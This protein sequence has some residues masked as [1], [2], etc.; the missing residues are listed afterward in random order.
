LAI[1]RIIVEGHGG[2]VEV[3]SAPGRGSTFIVWLPRP[4][5][6]REAR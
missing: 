1:V 4:T 2:H 3:Q 5:A 6:D